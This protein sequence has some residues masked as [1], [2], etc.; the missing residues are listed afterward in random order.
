MT[1]LAWMLQVTKE[2]IVRVKEL[3]LEICHYNLKERAQ[4]LNISHES[5]FNILIDILRMRSV[6]ERLLPKKLNLSAKRTLKS[7]HFYS[8]LTENSTNL[9]EQA[10]YSPDMAL[11]DIFL[12]PKLKFPLWGTRFKS[13]AAIK[14]NSRKELKPIPTLAYTKYMDLI[15]TFWWL[16]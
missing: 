8:V 16:I 15:N 5:V 1:C 12:F 4:E 6:A 7:Y 14:E 13:I 2:N 11:C 10:P 9:I 3:V